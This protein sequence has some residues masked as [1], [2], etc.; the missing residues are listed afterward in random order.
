V[1][2][3]SIVISELLQCGRVVIHPEGQCS[4]HDNP[5]TSVLLEKAII[6]ISA[7][8]T[9]Q[10]NSGTSPAFLLKNES[11]VKKGEILKQLCREQ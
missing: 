2:C 6:F 1:Y 7:L 4:C 10:C 8:C 3:P 5:G 11:S 9:G